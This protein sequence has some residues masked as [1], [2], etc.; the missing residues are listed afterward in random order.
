MQQ[1]TT[2]GCTGSA[3]GGTGS[4]PASLS[5]KCD[6]STC[7]LL[8]NCLTTPADASCTITATTSVPTKLNQLDKCMTSIDD[9]TCTASYGQEVVSA[10]KTGLVGWVQ[11][12]SKILNSCTPNLETT[13]TCELRRHII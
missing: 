7:T 13:V 3:N 8:T 12:L 11:Q 5:A 9:A 10:G 4:L 2:A 6:Q 1:P